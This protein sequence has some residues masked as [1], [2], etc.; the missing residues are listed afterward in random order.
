MSEISKIQEGNL[1]DLLEE[2]NL[3]MTMTFRP[4]LSDSDSDSDGVEE[5]EMV[6]DDDEEKAKV[7]ANAVDKVDKVDTI[8]TKVE[9]ED[10]DEDEVDV[11]AYLIKALQ[12][13]VLIKKPAR[14]LSEYIS[15]NKSPRRKSPTKSPLPP[16]DLRWVIIREKQK[17]QEEKIREQMM[18]ARKRLF[19]KEV[20]AKELFKNNT[21]K[22]KQS[23]RP[24]MRNPTAKPEMAGLC[25]CQDR[26]EWRGI[27]QNLFKNDENTN[28]NQEADLNKTI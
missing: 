18:A 1:M 22:Q 4:A 11:E 20:R 16:T 19:D 12:S 17:I 26:C 3:P 5:V 9:D 21:P 23:N 14:P 15:P 6:E 13:K 27:C 2:E 10:E 7:D 24:K 8:M 25:G 28:P